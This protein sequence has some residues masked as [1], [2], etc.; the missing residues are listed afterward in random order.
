MKRD[1]LEYIS[2]A[3]YLIVHTDGNGDVIESFNV[4][5]L[6]EA[7]VLFWVYFEQ[8]PWSRALYDAFGRR[9]ALEVNDD[10]PRYVFDMTRE[11]MKMTEGL[12]EAK[13]L[14]QFLDA[15]AEIGVTNE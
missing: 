8:K 6:H 11:A 10:V 9:V 15:I 1:E 4:S 7:V 3:P 14:A 12:P 13:P 2:T 5:G